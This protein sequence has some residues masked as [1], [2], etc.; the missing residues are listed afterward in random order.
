MFEYVQECKATLQ[1][2]REDKINYKWLT[3]LMNKNQ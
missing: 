3:E 1:K 2:F